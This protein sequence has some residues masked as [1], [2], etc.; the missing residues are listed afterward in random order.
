MSI[1]ERIK[2]TLI[3]LLKKDIKNLKKMV[4]LSFKLISDIGYV[5][6]MAF[7]QAIT[8]GN[9]I[10]DN[11]PYRSSADHSTNLKQLLI[12]INNS[13]EL[14][15]NT[16]EFFYPFFD[17]HIV[18]DPI[19]EEIYSNI[20]GIIYLT[21]F[22]MSIEEGFWGINCKDK[23]LIIYLSE[24][25]RRSALN[26][27][28]DKVNYLYDSNETRKFYKQGF[29][30]IDHVLFTQHL[31]IKELD[32]IIKGTPDAWKNL[33]NM[34]NINI[35]HIIEFISFIEYLKKYEYSIWYQKDDIW[36]SWND[37]INMYS[38]QE[39][40]KESFIKI[41]NLFSA[42]YKEALEWG[43]S[44]PFIKIGQWYGKWPFYHH[45]L[46][47]NLSFLSL[48]IRKFS[49]EWSKTVGSELAKVSNYIANLLPTI[50]NI[51]LTTLKKKKG[52]GDIDLGIYNLKSNHLIICEIKTVFDRFRTNYQ[53]KNYINQRVNFEKANEQLN[54][55]EN[56]LVTNLWTLKEI[57]GKNFSNP[58]ETITKIILT[59][60]DVRNINLG[61][62]KEDILCCNFKI[63]Q[64]LY[65]KADGDLGLL[66]TTIYQMSKIYCYAYLKRIKISNSGKSII[67]LQVQSDILPPLSYLVDKNISTLALAELK[68]LGHVQENFK[69]EK[70]Y[71][72]DVE[73]IYFYDIPNF[74]NNL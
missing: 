44:I 32:P 59:W 66:A 56:A 4:D 19:V 38:R 61:T 17:S 5:I 20:H 9:I 40:I 57:F 8:F 25:I 16:N 35:E 1:S 41:L 62:S 68:T 37:Y 71:D 18:I 65:K 30:K 11:I 58:P 31:G 48:L 27:L 55:I 42:S 63:F 46:H 21:N 12:F 50:E 22:L 67:K 47:P 29:E 49:S 3:N 2:Q 6:P 7:R 74:D 60:W 43:I 73:D 70:T 36:E 72:R 24:N 39:I 14:N 10:V 69:I 26:L 23:F 28:S 15:Q 34:L 13:F 64:Y 52:V 33:L 51:F 54:K 53:L 45:V